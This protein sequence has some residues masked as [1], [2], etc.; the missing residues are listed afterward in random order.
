MVMPVVLSSPHT[1][2]YIITTTLLYISYIIMLNQISIKLFNLNEFIDHADGGQDTAG[3]K[4]TSQTV[5]ITF[6]HYLFYTCYGVWK[7]HSSYLYRCP[8]GFL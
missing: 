1:T 6:D 5:S 4:R 2:D 3:Y 8:E 7:M